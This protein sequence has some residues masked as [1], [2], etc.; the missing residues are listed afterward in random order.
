MNTNN[1]T[2]LNSLNTFLKTTLLIASV[3][4]LP[5]PELAHAAG[6]VPPE[7]GELINFKEKIDP[8]AMKAMKGKGTP[9]VVEENETHVI[10]FEYPKEI[11]Y[12]GI[13]FRSPTKEWNF[14]GYSGVEVEILNEGKSALPFAL[15]VDNAD[16]ASEPWNTATDS[17]NAGE[18]KKIKALFGKEINMGKHSA[19]GQVKSGYALDPAHV[20]A[21]NVFVVKPKDGGSFK[22]KSLNAIKEEAKATNDTAAPKEEAKPAAE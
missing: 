2:V 20:S 13:T 10:K 15:R 17:I 18:T 1:Q 16:G 22:I 21:V 9:S 7:T 19:S 12:P 3:S 6:V 11:K 14:T 4:L 5:T 8:S